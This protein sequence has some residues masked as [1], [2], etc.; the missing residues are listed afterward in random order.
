MK[1]WELKNSF[2]LKIMFMAKFDFQFETQKFANR[3]L[4]E[5]SLP[6]IGD[7]VDVGLK[8]GTTKLDKHLIGKIFLRAN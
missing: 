3:V 8:L 4:M 7:I 2:C 6:Q 5:G 1:I